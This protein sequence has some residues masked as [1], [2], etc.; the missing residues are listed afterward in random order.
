MF[1]SIFFC[2][3]FEIKG[4]LFWIEQIWVFMEKISELLAGSGSATTLVRNPKINP[5]LP[6]VSCE[7]IKI[8]ISMRND[9]FIHTAGKI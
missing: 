4:F 6:A 1:F 9:L 7:N 8:L 3:I 2:E 5:S